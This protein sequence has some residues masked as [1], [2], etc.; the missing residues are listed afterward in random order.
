MDVT[1]HMKLIE[2]RI[3]NLIWK[4][5]QLKAAGEDYKE[6]QKNLDKMLRVQKRGLVRKKHRGSNMTPAKK[7]D[8]EGTG[9]PDYMLTGSKLA[10]KRKRA[11]QPKSSRNEG[12]FDNQHYMVGG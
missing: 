10:R 9:I 6:Y 12:R 3:P 2:N 11:R 7:R 8:I 5:K 1:E 4:I